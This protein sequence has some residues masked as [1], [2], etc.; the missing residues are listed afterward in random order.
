M[1]R[2]HFS[3][4]AMDMLKTDVVTKLVFLQEPLIEKRYAIMAKVLEE[5]TDFLVGEIEKRGI[6]SKEGLQKIEADNLADLSDLENLPPASSWVP[7]NF[8]D[9]EWTM[10]P[11]FMD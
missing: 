11:S 7:K 9:G 3:F 1:R 8:V 2:S 5:S 10:Q 4:A 6:M